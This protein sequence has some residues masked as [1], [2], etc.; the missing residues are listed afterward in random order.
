MSTSF[1][2]GTYAAHPFPTHSLPAVR[3]ETEG[4]EHTLAHL[5][6]LPGAHVRLGAQHSPGPKLAKRYNMCIKT[7]ELNAGVGDGDGH[8]QLKEAAGP[9]RRRRRCRR[10][11]LHQPS[12]YSG[13]KD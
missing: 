3:R 1:Y 7:H 10:R 12:L 4:G 6:P 5:E 13:K 9:R 8:G 2:T 11:R